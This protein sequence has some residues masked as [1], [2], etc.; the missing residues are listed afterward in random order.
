[1]ASM[2]LVV[3]LFFAT[4]VAGG[5]TAGAQLVH[6]VLSGDRTSDMTTDV[7]SWSSGRIYRVGDHLLF[8]Y[9]SPQDTIVELASIDEYYSCDLTN[10][11]KM[12][13]EHV[14]KVPLDKEGIRYFASSSYEKCK[15]GLKLP[16]HVNPPRDYP[17]APP[18]PSS[19]PQLHGIPALIVVFIGLILFK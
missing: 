9:L 13:T 16:V 6:H 5:N 10:P 3:A 18:T 2:K 14:N 7:G 11:I 1:M 17:A 8:R 15:N 4:V 12:Y 19:A